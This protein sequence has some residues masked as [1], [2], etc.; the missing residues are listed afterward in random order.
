MYLIP[1]PPPSPVTYIL[2][3]LRKDVS[4]ILNTYVL[5]AIGSSK[6]TSL[7]GLSTMNRKF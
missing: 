5:P 3:E 4:Q 6:N 7:P 2:R 1:V